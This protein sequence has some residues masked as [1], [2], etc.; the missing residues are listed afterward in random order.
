MVSYGLLDNSLRSHS[1]RLKRACFTGVFKQ[2]VFR[3][4][5]PYD[6]SFFGGPTIPVPP[7]ARGPGTFAEGMLA[8]L[9]G[10]LPVLESTFPNLTSPQ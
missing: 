7:E 1:K 5:I 4:Y 2:V 8:V 3:D 6:G 10:D 9:I